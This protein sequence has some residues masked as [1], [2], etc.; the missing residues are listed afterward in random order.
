[1]EFRASKNIVIGTS[2]RKFSAWPRRKKKC[3]WQVT[4]T[5]ILVLIEYSAPCITKRKS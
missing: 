3:F 4:P 1:M 5:E 2:A